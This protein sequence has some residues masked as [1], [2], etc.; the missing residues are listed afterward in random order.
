MRNINHSSERDLIL[1]LLAR[2]SNAIHV[3]VQQGHTYLWP[4]VVTLYWI[5]TYLR[6]YFERGSRVCVPSRA[7]GIVWLTMSFRFFLFFLFPFF[8]FFV[9]VL[10]HCKTN[11]RTE[12]KTDRLYKRTVGVYRSRE[13]WLHARILSTKTSKPWLF[14]YPRA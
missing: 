8:F 4:H 7:L 6:F 12:T 2:S 9:F 14:G 13:S 1:Q 5:L 3:N 11:T 10:Y